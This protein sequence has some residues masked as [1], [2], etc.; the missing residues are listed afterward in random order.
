[1][2]VLE[3][4]AG[5]PDGMFAVDRQQRIAFW[6][7]GARRILGFEARS[8][9]RR[10]CYDVLGGIDEDSSLVCQKRCAAFCAAVRGTLSPTR[11]TLVRT[12]SG[13]RQSVNVTTFVLPSRWHERALLA[14]VF[15]ETSQAI[16]SRSSARGGHAAGIRPGDLVAVFDRL[17]RREIEILQLLA[18]GESTASICAGLCISST[19]FRS[20]VQHIL[21]KLGAHSRIEAVV[22]GMRTGLVRLV[23]PRR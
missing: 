19:T 5:T 14:H 10:F 13:G 9:L 11:N 6:N 18:S 20:H 12:G 21:T 4:L 23:D 2:P 16:G 3:L 22:S 8:V 1:M 7:D 15:R 17:T